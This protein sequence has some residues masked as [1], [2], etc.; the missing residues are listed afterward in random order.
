M[1]SIIELVTLLQAKAIGAVPVTVHVN[2]KVPFNISI[3]PGVQS[4]VA[5]DTFVTV[6][7]T[8]VV[9]NQVLFSYYSCMGQ[10]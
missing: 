1:V 7:S 10:L 4:L 9:Q 3:A 6:P 5:E 2:T 8:D